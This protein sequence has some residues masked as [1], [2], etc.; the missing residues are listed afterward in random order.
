LGWLAGGGRQNP[1]TGVAAGESPEKH[2][3][4]GTWP[5]PS[6][7]VTELV[8]DCRGSPP[9]RK[10]NLKALSVQ[11]WVKTLLVQAYYYYYGCH[12][13][14]DVDGL[15]PPISSHNPFLRPTIRLQ[16]GKVESPE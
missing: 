7:A 12:Q 8:C 9:P 2:L 1:S 15:F 6:A 5:V 11:P 10:A 14:S 4:H 13:F 16:S 3:P